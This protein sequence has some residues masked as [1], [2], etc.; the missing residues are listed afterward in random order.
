MWFLVV[1]CLSNLMSSLSMRGRTALNSSEG[2]L[3]AIGVVTVSH[4]F[5]RIC[6]SEIY[7]PGERQAASPPSA[8]LQPAPLC[9]K[10]G[11]G[12]R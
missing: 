12:R 10:G 1:S 11:D 6:S 9:S 8:P 4:R 5:F 2:I 3:L 7:S